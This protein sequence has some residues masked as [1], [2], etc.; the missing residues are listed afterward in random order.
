LQV[1]DANTTTIAVEIC[2][3][4]DDTAREFA[5]PNSPRDR[6]ATY[7]GE[8]SIIAWTKSVR[9]RRGCSA[10]CLLRNSKYYLSSA[11]TI[12][13]WRNQVLSLAPSRTCCTWWRRERALRSLISPGCNYWGPRPSFALWIFAKV[14]SAKP[15]NPWS[16]IFIYGWTSNLF[17]KS[18]KTSGF[19]F[20]SSIS[21]KNKEMR[22]K[23]YHWRKKLS[24]LKELGLFD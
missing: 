20:E 3:V 13:S 16:R 9:V 24:L 22:A 8:D 23:T 4:P 2:V 1:P 14:S 12:A 18:S 6:G 11:S 10:G 19:L 5:R 7:R 17:T 15:D 21:T